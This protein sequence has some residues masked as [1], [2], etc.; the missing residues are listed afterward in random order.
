MPF[1]SKEEVVDSPAAEA[2]E[3]AMITDFIMFK[4]L[5]IVVGSK[6]VFS[7]DSGRSVGVLAQ[8]L[9]ASIAKLVA[10]ARKHPWYVSSFSEKY[11]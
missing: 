4:G 3:A 5:T 1:K 9:L 6:L 10:L 2:T 8:D 7:P 11:A